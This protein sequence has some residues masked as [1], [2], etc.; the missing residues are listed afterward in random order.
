MK[1]NSKVIYCLFENLMIKFGLIKF[2]E[3]EP[4]ENA[5]VSSYFIK[6]IRNI[7]TKKLSFQDR[8]IY[9]HFQNQN[10]DYSLA[11]HR[12]FKCLFK[13]EFP[14]PD[15]CLI[16]DYIFAHEAEK[17]TGM[18]LYI[19]Y[20][21]LGMIINVK[22]QLLSRD[23][24]GM[25]QI[26]MN[27]PKISP[28]TTLLSMADQIAEDLAITPEEQPPK[29]EEK[30][31]E[32]KK[33]EETTPPPQTQPQPQVQSPIPNPLGQIN[34][35]LMNPNLLV[36]PTMNNLQPNPMNN[37]MLAMVMQQMANQQLN[38][39]VNNVNTINN[40]T[41]TKVNQ[42]EV[43]AATALIELKGIVNKYQNVMK[44]EDKNRMDF[45][46]DSLAKKF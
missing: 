44:L 6:R 27:Y 9:S 18:F 37:L 7:I 12:W 19:D 38:N 42:E 14:E 34:P 21:A 45:L 33:I 20:I 35:L 16:W 10:L 36:N 1:V 31:E 22:Y 41:T 25:F 26:L 39:N 30:K 5:A 32:E 15:T 13:R 2:F 3:D 40:T 8:A 17:N 23:S 46:I 4:K 43:S 29:I 24:N 11:F 28:I